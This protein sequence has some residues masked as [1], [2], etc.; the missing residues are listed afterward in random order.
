MERVI[1]SKI[2][3]GSKDLPSLVVVISGMEKSIPVRKAVEPAHLTFLREMIEFAYENKTLARLAWGVH[4]CR[5]PLSS[6]S[7]SG[8]CPGLALSKSR[9]MVL[10]S[11][12][13][14]HL[15]YRCVFARAALAA[16]SE[17][18]QTPAHQTPLPGSLHR[19][20]GQQRLSCPRWRSSALG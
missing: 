4:Q 7:Q 12:G 16:H 18:C 17:P 11:A 19:L 14:G 3:T 20:H 1:S 15:L 2:S 10:G 8:F 13:I 5:L 9:Q 6:L